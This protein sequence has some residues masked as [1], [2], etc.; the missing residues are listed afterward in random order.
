MASNMTPPPQRERAASDALH[1][2][3]RTHKIFQRL[4]VRTAHRV[5]RYTT[6]RFELLAAE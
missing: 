6:S 5:R 4:L 1:T 3:D 2:L